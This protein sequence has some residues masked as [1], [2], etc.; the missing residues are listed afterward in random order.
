MKVD[1]EELLG[2]YEVVRYGSPGD[3]EYED[4]LNA[5]VDAVPD[6]VREH[7]ALETRVQNLIEER[8]GLEWEN[9]HIRY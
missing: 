3:G 2:Y 5:I 1:Y 4:A 6:I 7:N 9:Q 8:N